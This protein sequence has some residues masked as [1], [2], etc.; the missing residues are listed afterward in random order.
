[1]GKI[2]AY[3]QKALVPL[4]VVS[5]FSTLGMGFYYY[6]RSSQLMPHYSTLVS[7]IAKKRGESIAEYVEKQ[8]QQ[9]L[10]LAQLP[11]TEKMIAG[12]IPLDKFALVM[13]QYADSF[14]FKN[15]L[16]IS[17][18]GE[19]IYT[20]KN[21]KLLGL[22]LFNR[23][24]NE[25]EL[26]YSFMRVMMSLTPDI[27]EFEFD[28]LI[29]NQALYSSV[30]L[31]KG[32]DL[33][34]MLSA[35]LDE[36]YLTTLVHNYLGLGET[37]EVVL[38][39]R[40]LEGTQI[41]VPTRNDPGSAFR[42]PFRFKPD[43]EFPLQRA[44][45]GDTKL[46]EGIDYRGKEVL[47]TTYYIPNADVGLVAK[48]DISEMFSSLSPLRTWVFILF[49]CMLVLGVLAFMYGTGVAQGI[50]RFVRGS[51]F[52]RKALVRTLIALICLSSV[53]AAWIYYY[54]YT[55]QF[56]ALEST[57]KLAQ[58]LIDDGV[59]KLN[60]SLSTVS[61]LAETMAADLN[62]GR[63]QK[64]D[65]VT[66]MKRDMNENENLFGMIVAYKPHAYKNDRRLYAPYITRSDDTFMVKQFEQLHDY[67][68]KESVSSKGRS[69]YGEPLL[70][71]KGM[72][73][74]PEIDPASNRLV[75][76][77]S[78]PF[79]APED[80]LKSN[81]LGVVV[82]M[83]VV[84]SMQEIVSQLFIGQTGYPFIV[85]KEGVYLYHP[86]NEYVEKQKTIFSIAERKGDEELYSLGKQMVKGSKGSKEYFDEKVGQ[87]I[88]VYYEPVKETEW[89]L[90]LIFSEQEIA[91]PI[92][93]LHHLYIW[94]IIALVF[95]L[96]LL[97]GLISWLFVT[98]W[99]RQLK[100][101]ALLSSCAFVLGLILL[102]QQVQTT[103]TIEAAQGVPI[104][105]KVS[106]DSFLN[107]MKEA[108][109]R[110]HEKPPIALA[111]GIFVDSWNFVGDTQLEMTSSIWQN[112]TKKDI[113]K[114]I[115]L[116]QSTDM[117]KEVLSDEN[118]IIEWHITATLAQQ[119]NYAQYPFDSQRITIILEHNDS[120]KN[121]ILVPDIASYESLVP[122]DIPGVNPS[123]RL[124]G[125]TIERSFFNY[126]VK[127]TVNNTQ[128]TKE[129][130]RLHFSIIIARNLLNALII[131]LLPL[132]VVLF[133]LFAIV[134]ATGKIG[135]TDS[136]FVTLTGYTSLLF[137]LLVLHRTLRSQ[138]PTGDVLYI[139]YLFFFTYL[140]ILVLIVHGAIVQARVKQDIIERV[141]PI[142]KR[143]FWPVQLALWF[144]ATV[145]IFY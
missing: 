11:E 80:E 129:R 70:E 91:M 79:Y 1:M 57:K 5:L 99:L 22:N 49:L 13:Q 32:K 133:S 62:A 10:T 8:Q 103:S 82:A 61:F 43:A 116:P 119:F 121:I 9:V 33:L 138:Y 54:R 48:I 88:W 94:F 65:L 35:Q 67:T 118:G 113:P 15:I 137:A 104:T 24:Y 134:C 37:G 110:R 112:Y 77:Y 144:I 78:I 125:Y 108:A 2:R 73:L 64:E 136:V 45:R 127:A 101:F 29:D 92:R 26:T 53:G 96:T 124:A 109:K 95:A 63:L 84:D 132:L 128:E 83:Y 145:I 47:A 120:S 126:E 105:S 17:P 51:I 59:D 102:W 14:M 114:E 3:T 30:P 28:P 6:Y 87:D 76:A 143:L 131:Y 44:V 90:G 72:W 42:K 69:W 142:L 20:L 71:R 107:E 12:E 34:G 39:K 93:T 122:T 60:R 36:N 98:P 123:F 85:S 38:G 46:V 130:A 68:K 4:F 140:T 135:T 117:S 27:S 89:S 97:S 106:L 115:Y 81:P 56:H 40:T 52:T 139:E 16:L 50:R 41:I 75:V 111:T 141:S 21:Q 19:L 66:S 55:E 58:K 18:K 31:F 100:I 23:P 7:A 86:I 74:K 25:S